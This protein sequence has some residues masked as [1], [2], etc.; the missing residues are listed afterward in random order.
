MKKGGCLLSVFLSPIVFFGIMMIAI[1]V[2][3]S[4][5]DE[6]ST[7]E[8]SD[9]YIP[10]EEGEFKVN[11]ITDLVERYRSY[12][13]EYAIENGIEQYVDVIM[14]MTMQ[15]SG[16]RLA[17]VM[18]SSESLGLPVNTITDPEESIKQGVSYFASVLKDADGKIKLALQAYNMGNGFI[19]YAK[20]NNN[21]NYSQALAFSFSNE[22]A[23]KLGWDGY[24][25]PNYVSNVFRYLEKSNENH[26]VTSGE[27]D[28]PL[29]NI[30]LTSGF[31]IRV[32]PIT[33]KKGSFHAGLD[34]SCNI[35]ENIKVVNDGV[36]VQVT[37]SNVGYGNY[38]IVEHTKDELSLYAHMS[39]LKVVTGESISQ[40]DTVGFCGSTGSSTGP[41]LHLEHLTELTQPHQEKSDPRIILGLEGE[42]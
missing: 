39:S 24:G 28:F 32:D 38:V 21:G 13:V 31:G 15:E 22:M 10:S 29:N 17:D 27:W 42:E 40:G 9:S 26:L 35:G 12:F 6:G 2:V 5:G 19:G 16:G 36:V 25:D 23:L 30:R 3:I 7:G 37:H 41:H 11:G 8:D 4:G 14:A 34:F 1:V 33:G 20:K 18:Q